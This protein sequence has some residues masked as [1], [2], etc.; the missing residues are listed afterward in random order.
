VNK[1]VT[2]SLLNIDQATLTIDVL[3]KLAALAAENW[4]VQLILVDN[5]SRSDQLRLLQDWISANR[6]RF[7]ETLF[8]AASRN[9]G[10]TGGRNLAFKLASKD[11]LLILDNDLVLPD[12]STWLERL[13]ETMDSNP[14]AA[15]AAPMLVFADRPEIVQATG[16]ALTERGRVGFINRGRAVK[17][18]PADPIEVI[19]TPTAC[20][21]LRKDA[22]QDVG[23]FLEVFYPVQYEDVDFCVRLHLA[24]WKTICD[25]NV[26]I[27]HIENVT[28]RNLEEHPFA[29]LTVRNGITFR[30]KWAALLPQLATIT[31]DE[32]IWERPTS[33]F[34]SAETP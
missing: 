8:V 31:Q 9:L 3:D 12:D 34:Q 15:I 25:C 27:K 1:E 7:E 6:N 22:Q 32:I 16:I 11:R 21:L 24:G 28:T 13:W 30:E 2:V 19:A 20:W 18:V 26:Q 33:S 4:K 10:C 5:G 23:I 14:R 17:N 29:R